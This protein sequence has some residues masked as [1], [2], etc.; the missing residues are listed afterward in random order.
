[1]IKYKIEAEVHTTADGECLRTCRFLTY[2]PLGDRP[3]VPF[4]CLY[5]GYLNDAYGRPQ[6][7]E[8][9]RAGCAKMRKRQ[10][11]EVEELSEDDCPPDCLHYQGDHPEYCTK[12]EFRR[13]GTLCSLQLHSV[14]HTTGALFH[15]QQV[16]H[17]I[18]PLLR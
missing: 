7:N 14:G 13:K 4:C 15:L 3:Q 16:G 5:P 6:A 18:C 2:L 17:R 9:C 8:L 10:P 11:E 1:M 12:W